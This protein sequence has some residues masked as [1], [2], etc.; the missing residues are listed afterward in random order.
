MEF[1]FPEKKGTG[2]QKL[3]PQY[4]EACDIIQKLL[5]YNHNHRMSATQALKHPYFKELREQDRIVQEGN[6]AGGMNSAA[7]TPSSMS[8]VF[9][10]TQK[11]HESMSVNSKSM[12]KISDN[13]SDGSFNN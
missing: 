1:D 10:M 13:A 5:I 11:A 12:S 8:K 3:V 6:I 7:P 4:P 2:L 9:R